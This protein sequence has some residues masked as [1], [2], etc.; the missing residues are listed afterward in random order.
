MRKDRAQGPAPTA[1]IPTV[2][3]SITAV[4]DNVAQRST[5]SSFGSSPIKTRDRW[6]KNQLDELDQ[7]IVSAVEIEHP[8]S[9]RGV[10]YRVVSAGAIDKTEKGYRRVGHQLTK[11]RAA[12]AIPYSWITDGTRLMRKPETW[13]DLDRML[14]SAA[15]SYR[16]ALWD[17]QAVEVIVLSEKDAI[18]GAIW[19][20]T[21]RWDVELGVT[22]GLLLGD[23]HALHR[24]DRVGQL[25]QGQDDVDLSAR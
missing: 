1:T 13:S 17:D 12:R 24:G 20:V 16:R 11:L 2:P 25:G 19:P 8:V 9:L 18:S 15:A 21:S 6:T 23:V 22:R 4:D 7:A 5:S 14:D 3:A 10:Y